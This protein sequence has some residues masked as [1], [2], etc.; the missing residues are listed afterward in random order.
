MLGAGYGLTVPP[1]NAAAMAAAGRERS[2]VAA[3]TINAVRQ[4]GTSLGIALLG[5]LL[6]VGRDGAGHASYEQAY[7]GGLHLVAVVAAAVALATA[8]L[9]ALTMRPGDHT[10][11]R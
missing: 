2:G 8:V 10:D 7:T 6:A 3:A 4:A 11:D 1:S 5:T 9:V